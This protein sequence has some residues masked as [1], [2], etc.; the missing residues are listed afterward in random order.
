MCSD[1]EGRMKLYAS[2]PRRHRHLIVFVTGLLALSGCLTGNDNNNVADHSQELPT[3]TMFASI[4]NGASLDFSTDSLDYS[5][6]SGDLK[7][8]CDRGFSGQFPGTASLVIASGVSGYTDGGIRAA[9]CR[10][11]ASS[12]SITSP[13]PRLPSGESARAPKEP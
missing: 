6:Q 10:P 9:G 5:G 2:S 11:S 4:P 13:C 3:G 7:F 1:P 8:T 12:P